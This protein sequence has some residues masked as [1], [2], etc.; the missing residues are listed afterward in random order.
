[1]TTISRQVIIRNFSLPYTQY[2]TENAMCL[3]PL[4]DI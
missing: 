4:D 2:K 1:M 3:K